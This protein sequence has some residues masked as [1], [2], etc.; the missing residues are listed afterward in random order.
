MR[1]LVLKVEYS[2]GIDCISH[3]A[4]FKVQMRTGRTSGI[5]AKRNRSSG[6][7]ILS[8][9]HKEFRQ[10][11]IYRFKSV[12]MT[13]NHIVAITTTFEVCKTYIAG[14]RGTNCITNLHLKVNPLMHAAETRTIAIWRRNISHS[15]H[16]EL[17]DID[18]GGFRH[19][20]VAER[21]DRTVVLVGLIK[22]VFRSFFLLENA[23]HIIESLLKFYFRRY[24]LLHCKEILVVGVMLGR[25]TQV[26][27]RSRK[28]CC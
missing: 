9:F 20:A 1:G 24:C 23:I 18:S 7:Y 2:R 5:A 21:I 19:F 14:E 4:R 17:A 22:V 6:L 16:T 28:Y 12:I 25:A 26:L 8:G 13:Q 3:K 27:R 10:V 11:T 15:R